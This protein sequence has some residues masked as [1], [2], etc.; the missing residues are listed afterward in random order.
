MLPLDAFVHVL[1]LFLLQDDLNEQLLQF[2]IAVV[3]AE[4]L[5]TVQS[6]RTRTRKHF[7]FT[8]LYLIC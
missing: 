3:D 1:F 6:Q 7:I 4:L 2:L 8:Y 5:K